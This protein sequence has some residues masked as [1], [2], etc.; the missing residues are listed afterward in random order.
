MILPENYPLTSKHLVR[1][2]GQLVKNH[3]YPPHTSVSCQVNLGCVWNYFLL[4]VFFPSEKP[5][6]VANISEQEWRK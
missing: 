6:W 4:E 1:I 3:Y 2:A 5:A